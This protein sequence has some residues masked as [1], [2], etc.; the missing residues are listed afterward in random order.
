M[1]IF[2]SGALAVIIIYFGMDI[3]L[4]LSGSSIENLK[5][6]ELDTANWI[7]FMAFIS[8]A[9]SQTIKQIKGE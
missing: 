2:L 6:S 7:L 5:D 3:M 4:L 8:G 9:V 1:R